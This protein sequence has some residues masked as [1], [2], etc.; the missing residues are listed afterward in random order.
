[1]SKEIRHQ[2][3]AKVIIAGSGMSTGGRILYHERDFLPDPDTTLAIVGFQVNGTLGRRLIEGVKK[4]EILNEKINVQAKVVSI[5]S[6]SAHGDY[7]DLIGWLGKIKGVEKTILIHGEQK[8][9]ENLSEII[10][11]ELRIETYLPKY[12]DTISL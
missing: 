12:G 9:R 3:G 11:N 5:D 4:I 7:R 8:A 1:Q 10:N 6:Y 2:F